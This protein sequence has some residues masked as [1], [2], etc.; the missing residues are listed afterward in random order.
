[1]ENLFPDLEQMLS[2][3]REGLL[4]T[5]QATG[6]PGAPAQRQSFEDYRWSR[7]ARQRC[8]SLTQLLADDGREGA[9]V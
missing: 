7:P 4:V 8:E 1:M 6:Q 3:Q 5:P 2:P 9:G